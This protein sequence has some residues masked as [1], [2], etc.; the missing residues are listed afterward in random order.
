M[1]TTA[2]VGAGGGAA[3]MTA[4]PPTLPPGLTYFLQWRI[5]TPGSFQVTAGGAFTTIMP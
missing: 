1:T 4:I 3:Y 5:Q 2:M